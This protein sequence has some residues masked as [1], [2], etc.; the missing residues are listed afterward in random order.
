MKTKLRRLFVFSLLLTLGLVDPASAF[1]EETTISKVAR[2]APSVFS[3]LGEPT[4]FGS[5]TGSQSP[6]QSGLVYS[7]PD[8]GISLLAINVT[9]SEMQQEG[10]I[11]QQVLRSSEG[12]EYLS[13][14]K[15]DG[16]VQ[17]IGVIPSRKSGDKLQFNLELPANAKTRILP[18]GGVLFL[19]EQGK[20]LA[21]IAAPWAFDSRGQE[22]KTRFE[23]SDGKLIQHVLHSRAKYAYPI[24]ADPWIGID[25]YQVPYVTKHPEG[26]RI[27]VKPTLWGLTTVSSPTWFAH[28][29]E[30]LTK[31]GRNA[32]LWSSTIQEQ[33]YCHIFGSPWS[34]PEYNMESWSPLVHYFQ[35]LFLHR[36]NP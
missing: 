8:L 7:R 2:I 27:N 9:S 22:V 20:M 34:F 15:N 26:Y 33:F 29:A 10:G 23:I 21:G 30:V 5:F 13:I 25:L 6:Q 17:V 14:P 35:S 28:R 18:S 19:D 16:S 36:C 1:V 12:I 24:V 32:S 31:L 11:S 4:R 3:N